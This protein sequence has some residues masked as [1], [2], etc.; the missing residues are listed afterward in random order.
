MLTVGPSG[1]YPTVQGAIGSYCYTGGTRT[2]A[3][4]PL[5]IAIDPAG[6]PYD[7][8][9]SLMQAATGYGDIAGDLVLKSMGPGKAV[10]QLQEGD[11]AGDDGL[12]IF[13]D[14]ANVILKD[15]ILCPSVNNPFEDD[16]LVMMESNAN[17][18]ENWI[19]FYGCIVTDTDTSGSPMISSP[20]NA[21]DEP[22]ASGSAM[23]DGDTLFRFGV[24]ATEFNSRSLFMEQSVIYASRH[25]NYIYAGG[26][27]GSQVRLHNTVISQ[28]R[29]AGIFAKSFDAPHAYIVTGDD[30]TQGILSGDRINCSAIYEFNRRLFYDYA[31]GIHTRNSE[32]KIVLV[33]KNTVIAT[34]Q[35]HSQSRGISSWATSD[36]PASPLGINTDLFKIHDVI[37][38]V[39]V[40][41][42]MDDVSN[43]A[44]TPV[45]IRRVTI[46]TPTQ[47]VWL[48]D[49][50]SQTLRITDSIFAHCA[51]AVYKPSE[52]VA[53]VVL[54]HCGLPSA[55]AAAIVDAASGSVNPTIVN[56]IVADPLFVTANILSPAGFDVRA[57]EYR[58][59]ASDGSDLCGGAN[60]AFGAITAIEPA[61]WE[62]YR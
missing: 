6:G 22:V 54:S 39:P 33:V 14:T 7:E 24:D 56:P 3:V 45:D 41:A 57:R 51:A 9:V 37:I 49:D 23:V 31:A 27:T 4:K 21:L 11:V 2:D 30:Q 52:P 28:S 13:Q 32:N 48:T 43:D 34:T 40:Q 8:A 17:S 62:N 60:Y 46:K 38:D 16:L 35:N 58:N 42:I 47:G 1:D 59:A 18:T 19:E 36:K 50:S 20:A 10:I 61:A 53:T 5:V 26:V 25:L 44:A 15:L 12:P 29:V 55:G